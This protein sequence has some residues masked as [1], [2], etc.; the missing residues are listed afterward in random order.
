[1]KRITI[2]FVAML[3]LGVVGCGETEMRE[4]RARWAEADKEN[5]RRAY[6]AGIPPTANPN[7]GRA[8]NSAQHWLDGYIEA[9]TAAEKR[10]GENP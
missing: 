4:A 2:L 1:M 10:K 8:P 7:V 5:G 9:K 3:L 6:R